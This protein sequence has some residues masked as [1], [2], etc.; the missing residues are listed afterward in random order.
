MAA[1]NNEHLIPNS[2][3]HRQRRRPLMCAP[4]QHHAA[5][6]LT[7]LAKCTRHLQGEHKRNIALHVAGRCEKHRSYRWPWFV[8]LSWREKS[9]R[10]VWRVSVVVGP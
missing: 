4:A 1:D 5:P 8:L 9:R 10:G 3:R 2:A 6:Q 7:P